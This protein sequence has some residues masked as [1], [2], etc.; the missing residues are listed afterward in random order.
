VSR[1]VTAIIISQSIFL[2]LGIAR[3]SDIAL[4]MHCIC[5]TPGQERTLLVNFPGTLFAYTAESMPTLGPV[6]D[7][8]LCRRNA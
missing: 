5:I 4:R 2:P 6:L 3:R 8:D 7:T 1:R